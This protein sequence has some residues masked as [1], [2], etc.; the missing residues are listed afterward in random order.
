MPARDAWRMR[1]ILSAQYRPSLLEAAIRE[2]AR[3]DAGED[4]A[5]PVKTSPILPVTDDEGDAPLPDLTPA[6]EA[7]R[8]A[9]FERITGIKVR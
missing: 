6:Q 7:A 3:H 1:A 5:P 2:D 8:R 9:K 4:Y